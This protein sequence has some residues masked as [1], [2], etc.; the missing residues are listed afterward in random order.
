MHGRARGLRCRTA[1]LSIAE[2]RASP[3]KARGM[4]VSAEVEIACSLALREAQRRRHEIITVEHLLY[5][6][7]HDE[8]TTLVLKKSG[9]NT[10]KLKTALERILDTEFS[11]VS[12]SDDVYPAASRGFHRV[13][14]RAAIHVE[15][16]GK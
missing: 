13:L 10:D 16:S 15:S 3:N 4:K 6:L 1:S 8:G 11:S 5:A 2:V 7:L 12:G 14:Q 9:A